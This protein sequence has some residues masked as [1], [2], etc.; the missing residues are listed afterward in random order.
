MKYNLAIGCFPTAKELRNTPTAASKRLE[1][2]KEATTAFIK[3]ELRKLI[4]TAQENDC[5]GSNYPYTAWFKY[6]AFVK[7]YTEHGQFLEMLMDA[8]EPLGYRI[9]EEEDGA[10]NPTGTVVITWKEFE[11]QKKRVETHLQHLR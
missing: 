4:V 1:E 3:D 2:L 7:D 9:H 11:P 5:K 6:P 10:R 8:L